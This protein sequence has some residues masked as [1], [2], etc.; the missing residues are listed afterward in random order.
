MEVPEPGV[1]HGVLEVTLSSY[2]VIHMGSPQLIFIK[3][4]KKTQWGK[5]SLFNKWCWRNWITTCIR[6]R[7]DPYLK[8]PQKT[9]SG[10]PAVAQWF[11]NS[12]AAARVTAEA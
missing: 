10:V 8:P 4:A 1:N 7:L 6:I 12:T 2:V 9:N 5:N 11:K 3:E